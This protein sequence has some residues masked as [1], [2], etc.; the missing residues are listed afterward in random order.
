VVRLLVEAGAS[1]TIAD[2]MRDKVEQ[3][4]AQYEVKVA[5]PEEIWAL[6][7]DVFCPCAL[8]AV[9][10]D[11]TLPELRCKVICGS[12]NNQLAEDRHG[13]ALG[14]RGIV[15]GPDYIANAGGAIIGA[16]SLYPGGFN[17]ERAMEAVSRIYET[18][19]KVI[20]LAKESSIPTY[21]AADLLAEQRIAMA[22]QVNQ[23]KRVKG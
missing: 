6:N 8:G 5:H 18:M 12:A 17:R 21:R 13:D 19:G 3:V 4:A 15:Y 7:V 9:I 22:R 23:V 10:N 2:I 11:A 1:V 16:D 14:Q 20:G